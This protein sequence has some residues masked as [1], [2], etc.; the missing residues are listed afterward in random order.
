MKIKF[1][2]GKKATEQFE[3]AMKDLFRAQKPPKHEPKKRIKE[4]KD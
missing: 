1:V 4:G 2:E 3:K